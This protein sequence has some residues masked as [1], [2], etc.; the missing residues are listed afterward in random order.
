MDTGRFQQ[1]LGKLEAY[2]IGLESQQTNQSQEAL[3]AKFETLVARA[4]AAKP[5]AGGAMI[6]AQIPSS[7]SAPPKAA[8]P[9]PSAPSGGAVCTSSNPI[10]KAFKEKCFGNIADLHKVTKEINNDFLTKAV[11]GY[12]EMI[13]SNEAVFEVMAHC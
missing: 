5:G 3:M 12:I 10:I 13:K 4:E 2:V 1:V 11:N 9:P 7:A 8:N 6:A